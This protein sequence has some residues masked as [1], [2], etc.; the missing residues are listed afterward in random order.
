ML[1]VV[2]DYILR[3]CV[4]VLWTT[5]ARLM[6]FRAM[7]NWDGI[8]LLL[9]MLCKIADLEEISQKQFVKKQLLSERKNKKGVTLLSTQL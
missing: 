6:Q 4:P 1:Q 2:K 9:T 5:L 8:K 3:G 7:H